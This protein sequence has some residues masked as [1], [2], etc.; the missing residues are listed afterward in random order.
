MDLI[1]SRSNPKI[2]QARALRQSKER[3][4]SGLFLVEGIRPVGEAVEAGAPIESIFYSP[5][6]LTSA[7]ARELVA[8]QTAQKT[9]CYATTPEVFASLADKDNPQGLLAV[10]GMRPASLTGLS[11]ANFAWGV[12]LV[13]P[14]DPGNI[15]A[16][17]RSI[18][19]VG[20]SGL[21][22]LEGGADPYHPQA[23]RASMGALFWHPI[24][25]TSFSEFAAW[26]KQGGY[27]VVGTSAHAE[28]DYREAAR[29]PRPLILLLG[30]EQ[31]G[32]S[33]EQMAAC[34]QVVSLPMRGKVTSLNLAV[35]A[36]VLLYEMRK[37]RRE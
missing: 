26:A 5:D 28:K 36:G 19:A 23:V 32:L 3:Q 35:A 29:Y 37:E 20:A 22:L 25:Q 12:A 14:Q 17:L 7:Y 13:T 6:Q 18:D 10:V 31:K 27:T 4:A 9:P 24:V 33:A 11:P 30:S 16:I 8:Q 21:L 1:T 2:K 15:G 34:T